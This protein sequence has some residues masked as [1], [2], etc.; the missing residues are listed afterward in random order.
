[1]LY[2][3]FDDSRFWER[4]GNQSV[5]DVTSQQIVDGSNNLK[6]KNSGM[7]AVERREG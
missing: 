2:T 5:C 4:W 6:K 1:M 3:H 7:T